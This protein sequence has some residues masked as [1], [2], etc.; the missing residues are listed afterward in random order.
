MQ[1][2][3][4]AFDPNVNGIEPKAQGTIVMKHNAPHNSD[5]QQRVFDYH[6][7]T[8][9]R[10][11][12]YAPGPGFLDWATQPNPF[13]RYAGA[14]LIP[15]DIIPPTEEPRYDAIFTTGSTSALRPADGA[16]HCTAL[17]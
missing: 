15:L 2:G 5:R 17:L 1:T 10:F 11:D 7:A 9:H 13:R 12:A 16:E 6:Q 4:N 14:R 8:K 3:H